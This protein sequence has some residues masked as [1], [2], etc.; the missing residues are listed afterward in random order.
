M[1]WNP[2]S[3]WSLAAYA[4]LIVVLAFGAA[5]SALGSVIVTYTE[6]PGIENSS[7]SGVQVFDFNSLSTGVS[8]NVGWSGVG[9]FNQLYI[10]NADQYGGATDAT[11]PNGTRYSVQG[12]GTSVSTSSLKLNQDSGYFGFWWSAG[13]RS[14]VLDFY[15]DGQLVAEFTTAS[16][17][18]SLDSSYKGNPRNR[19]LDA[20]EPFAFINFYGDVNTHWD[21]IVFRNSTSSGFE[22]DNYTSRISTYNFNND[23]GPLPG[24]AVQRIT[25][26]NKTT[27]SSNAKGAALWGGAAFIP[28]APAPPMPLMVAFGLVL[29]LKGRKSLSQKKSEPE[30][31]AEAQFNC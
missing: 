14:N 25:G 3:S 10:K 23:A 29:I 2:R 24:V 6:N 26:T 5:N 30:L 7:L 28:G 1:K 31:P 18:G 4:A 15:N 9:T 8:T 27:L 17:L 22:S 11:H 19:N 12:A 16:L 21:Q 20:G 13:D